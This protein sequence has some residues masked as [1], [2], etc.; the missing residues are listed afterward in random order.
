MTGDSIDVPVAGD[1]SDHDG[2][3][4]RLAARA[5]RFGPLK[6][7]EFMDAA[8]YDP[9]GGF[10]ET[11]G[12]A[13]RRGDFLT[14]PELGPLF[15]T[16]VAAALDG[17]WEQLGR[18]DPFVVVEA[19]AGAGTLARDVLAAAPACSLAL[20]YVLVER[21]ATLR[22]AQQ[23]RLALEEPAMA[24]GPANPVLDAD[25]DEAVAIPGIGPL[26]TSLAELP[27]LAL[28]GVIL[29]NELLDNLA[30]DLLEWR[31]GGWHEV[32]IFAKPGHGE[33]LAELLIPAAPDQAAHATR[34]AGGIDGLTE[35]ARIPV[36][37]PAADWL[38]QAL[39]VLEQGRLIVIDY[40]DTT[41]ALARTPPTGWLRTFRQHQVALSPLEAPGTQDITCVVAVDQLAAVRPPDED[42]SQREWLGEHGVPALAAAAATTW[43]ERAAVGDL[44][45][46]VARSRVQEAEALLDPRGL[47]GHRV[48]E[49]IVPS[50]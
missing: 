20:R 22:A 37:R 9:A 5:R 12:H 27:S 41:S 28:T 29:A 4:A 32:R 6:W 16:A 26:V 39:T 25:E 11:G 10:Y 18:P 44:A 31:Q 40:A 23:E 42:R 47:G 1:A 24:L 46:L 13:G 50:A 21:S 7:S 19:A 8:L 43:R 17:T 38:R 30:V 33:A 14:S 48:L 35:G 36:Q 3:R 34:L 2:L 49:W 15:A 45:A